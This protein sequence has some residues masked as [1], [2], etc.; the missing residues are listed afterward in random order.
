MVCQKAVG[1]GTVE[2]T[3]QAEVSLQ[4]RQEWFA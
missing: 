1:A 2:I 4:L 3:A